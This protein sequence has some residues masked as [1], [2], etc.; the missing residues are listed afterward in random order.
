MRTETEH[1]I[2]LKD[3]A[4]S[5]YRITSVDL[6]FRILSENTRVRAQLTVEP[7]EGTAPGT[8]LVLD[9]DGLVLGSIA[10]D[11]APLMLSDYAADDD[12]LTVYEPPLRK[13]I[14]ETEVTLQPENNT[15]L[16]GLYRSG[17][18]W[19]TQCEPE[20]FRRITYYLDRPDNLAVFK[21][22]MTA[23]L[24]EAPVLL[25]N[26]NLIDK[27]DAGDG[28]HYAVWED[29]FP[30]PAYLFALVAGDL[31]SI[32]DN[33]TTASG[34][35]VAL[36]IYCTHGKEDQCLWAMDSLK[37]SMAW[38]ERRFGR[39]Y[40]LDIFNIVAVSDFNF[41]A[42]ENKGLNIFNDRLVFA[43]PETATDGNYD[44]IERVIAHEYFHNWTGNRITCRDWFQL[45]LKEGLTVYRDQEFTSDERSRAV[46]RISDVV[47]L[48]SAQFPED[49]GPLAHPPRPDQ[50]REINNFYTTTV[51]E[52]GAEI[53]RMLATLLGEAGFR[54]GMDLYFER[55]DGEATT[56]EAFLASFADANGMD[57]DQFKIWYLEAGTPRLSVDEVYDVQKQTYTLKFRQETAP[58]PNQPSK[59]ARVLPIKFGLLGPN[60]SPMGWSGVSGAEVRDEMI[61]LNSES[62]EVTF[63]GIANRPVPSLLR[64]FSAPVILES[65]ASQD[66]QLFLAR[67]DSDPF[68]RWQALQNVG[69][70][71]AVN[72]VKGTPWT[73]EAVAAL[74]QAMGD[75][76]ASDS[77]DD[78]FKALALSLPDE[79]L[80]GREIGRDVDPDAIDRVWHDLLKALFLP[81]ADPLKATYERLASDA[82]YS[83]D[84]ASTGRRALRNRALGLLVGSGAAGATEL[85]K[86]QYDDARNMTDRMAALGSSTFAGTSFAPAL[87]ADFRSR[88]G[89][90]PLVLDKWLAVTAA[91]P[92]DGVIDDMKAILA[93]PSFPRTNPNR[94]RALVG[95]FAMGNVTQFTRAD[96]AGF[97]FVAEFV[98]DVDKVNPQV[99]A[100]VLTGFRIWPMLD[101][102]RRE[103]AKAALTGLQGKSLSRN[104]ADIL[105]RTLA[106]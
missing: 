85:A 64:G 89:A 72:A 106:G 7:R 57:L 43:Q 80:I 15:K 65:K 91:Q 66:D 39:E 4:P 9:G 23:L 19:C 42:M 60:G 44:G 13:F 102:G 98:A 6:D 83:P 14:L 40:D 28:L 52:K 54:G 10:I 18:T 79:Q 32:S 61:V 99:A 68:N 73:Q 12:G 25:A 50:Y 90:D 53:V 74:S 33:F 27:G 1:T 21:V 63:T 16:M 3:Y 55:H 95:S 17:G 8:P 69:M 105:T 22:R 49:G 71:L 26:G 20:G 76:L 30:K 31:G 100:R 70:A 94:L 84:A 88:Y 24:S 101:A 5:P 77:L 38:D 11:G 48:R 87:L 56:I 2:Y 29:P 34:R 81:L 97:R 75:T 35:K 36:A 67:H 37:R 41:G 103:A 96:G 58:T 62:A 45:C 86:A 92:R 93:D 51:Y 47:G 78:A 59:A 82:P 104:T 46:K